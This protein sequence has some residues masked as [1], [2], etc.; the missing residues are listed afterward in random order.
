MIGVDPPVGDPVVGQVN[1]SA[2][3]VGDP[4][5]RRD[6]VVGGTSVVVVHV[7]SHAGRRLAV[8][9]AGRG[10]GDHDPVREGLPHRQF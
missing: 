4:E 5:V 10:V 2:G 9:R 1:G 7:Q 8:I 6:L 3:V